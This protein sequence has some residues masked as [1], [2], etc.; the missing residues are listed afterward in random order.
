[1]KFYITI[2]NLNK[3][4]RS[5]LNLKLYSI[6]DV[7]KIIS[8]LDYDYNDIDK[9]GIFLINNE[10]TNKINTFS[11][12]KRI[13]GIFYINPNI[14]EGIIDNLFESLYDN[15][16]ITDIIL[17]DDYNIPK[18]KQYYHKFNEIIFFPSIKKI[19]LTEYNKIKT[20]EGEF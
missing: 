7:P 9:Y 12:S 16:K 10:I 11:K 2:E 18:L 6:I 1:M 5:F 15:E 17:L 4:K 3:L 20:L 8:S 13:R 14:N 19:R